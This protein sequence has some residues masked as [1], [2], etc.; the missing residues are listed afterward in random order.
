MTNK[1]ELWMD[2]VNGICAD[3]CDFVQEKLKEFGIKLTDEKEDKIFDAVQA[4]LELEGT[5][6]YRNYN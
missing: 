1:K 5:G 3:T 2:D 4:V 6:D